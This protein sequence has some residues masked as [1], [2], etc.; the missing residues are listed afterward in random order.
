MSMDTIEPCVCVL[1]NFCDSC[2]VAMLIY[3]KSESL[4]TEASSRHRTSYV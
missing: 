2:R 1:F 3:M 4:L